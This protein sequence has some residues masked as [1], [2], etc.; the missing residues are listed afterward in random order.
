MASQGII[1]R[2]LTLARDGRH[3]SMSD[4]ET[5]LKQEGFDAV[6]DHLRGSSI[7][8]Q[9]RQAMADARQQSTASAE[10]ADL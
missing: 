10:G 2:A 5:R 6:Y 1:E 3:R 4:I 7:R 9:L 8:Q